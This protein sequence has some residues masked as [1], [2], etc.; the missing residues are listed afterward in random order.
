MRNLPQNI[1]ATFRAGL[2]QEIVA[3]VLKNFSQGEVKTR[4]RLRS[5]AHRCAKTCSARLAT[6]HCDDKNLFSSG[7]VSGFNVL[8]VNEYLILDGD[9]VQFAGTHAINA[10]L[11]VSWGSSRISMRSPSR[12]AC[13]SFTIGGCS[14]FFQECGPTA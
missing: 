7:F 5:G 9:R 12:L 1:G 13:Q 10:I 3:A 14:N 8:S 6:V 4:G 2:R 11:V